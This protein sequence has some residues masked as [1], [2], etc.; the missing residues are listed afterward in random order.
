[1]DTYGVPRYG[2]VNP[3]FFTSVTFPYEF[4]IMFGDI[5]HGGV[6]LLFGSV[7]LKYYSK[8]RQTKAIR[9]LL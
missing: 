7:L 8:L 2:E 9:G 5:G 4:G 6:L 1:V 3:G